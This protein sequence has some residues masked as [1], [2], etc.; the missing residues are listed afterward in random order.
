MNFPSYITEQ[1]LQ[2]F[3]RQAFLED[4]GD[5]DHSTL[6]AVPYDAIQEAELKVKDDGI[7]AGIELAKIIFD[8]F[9]PDLKIEQFMTDGDHVKFGDVAFK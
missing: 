3:I 7:I 6:A 8:T 4:V 9:D 5:G 2:H 1:K